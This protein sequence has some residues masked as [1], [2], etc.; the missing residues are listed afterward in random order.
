MDKPQQ[1]NTVA[2]PRL[3]LKRFVSRLTDQVGRR[4]ADNGVSRHN[5]LRSVPPLWVFVTEEVAPL[6]SCL[7]VLWSHIAFCQCCAFLVCVRVCVCVLGVV[8]LYSP[9]VALQSWDLIVECAIITLQ[10]LVADFQ[11]EF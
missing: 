7:F 10:D 11:H 3:K 8:Q 9:I 6:F 1:T 4:S 5:L 2:C